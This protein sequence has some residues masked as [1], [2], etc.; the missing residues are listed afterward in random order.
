MKKSLIALMCLISI[1]TNAQTQT[2]LRSVTKYLETYS[3]NAVSIHDP[4]IVYNESDKY[5]YIVG[6]H[7]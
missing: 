7:M 2:R 1:G 5:Y 4:S 3:A 6:S